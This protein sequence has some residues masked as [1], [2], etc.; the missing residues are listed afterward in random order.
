MIKA[1]CVAGHVFCVKMWDECPLWGHLSQYEPFE[2]AVP[3]SP[4]FTL[5]L[6]RDIDDSGYELFLDQ[7]AG[8]GETK[9]RVWRKP[10]GWLFDMSPCEPNPIA[11]TLVSND[12]FSR[13]CLR[14]E[15][16]GDALFALNNSLML[17]FAFRTAA[18]D[19]LEIHASVIKNGGKA[20]MFLAPSGTGKSTQSRMW[21]E[22]IPGS[23]LLN[24]DN[25]VVRL[26]DKGELI[27]YGSPWSGKTPCYK[28]DSC[29]AGAFVK[30]TR[31]PENSI[32]QLSIFEAYANLYSSS[33]GLKSDS[34][35][36]DALHSTIEKAV[37]GVKS[38]ELSCL[39]DAEAARVCYKGVTGK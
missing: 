22:N 21:L 23:T 8:K 33:S 2:T 35:M 27:V 11:G 24:D 3:D 30:I 13:A 6:T 28:N 15:K 34:A 16:G 38:F 17:V 18:F 26:N 14:I 25:P 1:F 29:P 7:Q 36:A 19:T 12:D 39:P 10:G 31:A 9:I 37:C 5:E 4:L 20:Y 32:R